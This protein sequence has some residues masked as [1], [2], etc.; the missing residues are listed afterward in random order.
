ME[1]SDITN[2]IGSLRFMTALL[3]GS[4]VLI[5]HSSFREEA[6][7]AAAAVTSKLSIE[8]KLI[9]PTAKIIINSKLNEIHRQS[10]IA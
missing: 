6:A 7:M 8:S 10:S 5:N 4:D 1:Q 3:R 2:W 9:R